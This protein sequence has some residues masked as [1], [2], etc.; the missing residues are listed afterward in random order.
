MLAALLL[1]EITGKLLPFRQQIVTK[2]SM[3]TAF[4]FKY[5]CPAV[6]VSPQTQQLCRHRRH[7]FFQTLWVT[8]IILRLW[9]YCAQS[10]FYYR[11][12]PCNV[13]QSFIQLPCVGE[14]LAI[15]VIKKATKIFKDKG[16][17]KLF[18]FGIL[19]VVSVGRTAHTTTR[20]LAPTNVAGCW[21]WHQHGELYIDFSKRDDQQ[22]NSQHPK[23]CI[24]R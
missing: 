8:S 13:W 16:L 20:A 21:N 19:T 11:P 10:S 14:F 17:P 4:S 5:Q 9:F 24:T 12:R 3:L 23:S 22:R 7:Q 6:S 1:R 18:F 15:Q 2:K